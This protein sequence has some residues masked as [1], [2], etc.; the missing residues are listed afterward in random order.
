MLHPFK[1]WWISL[2]VLCSGQT[3]GQEILVP[4]WIKELK[5]SNHSIRSHAVTCDE[6]G[7]IYWAYDVDSMQRTMTTYAEKVNHQGELVWAKPSSLRESNRSQT[8]SSIAVHGPDV[9]V[10]GT[11][12]GGLGGAH[13]N[14]RLLKIDAATGNAIWQEHEDLGGN[15]FDEYSKIAFDDGKM[16]L[17]G[18][19][20]KI[21]HLISEDSYLQIRQLDT[22][23]KWENCYG[24]DTSNSK[25]DGGLVVDMEYVYAAGTTTNFNQSS[26]AFLGN[27]DKVTGALKDSV[28]FKIMVNDSLHH[29]R[30]RDMTTDGQYLYLC[31]HTDFIYQRGF[32]AKYTKSLEEVW[33]VVY[34][35]GL[36]S[37]NHAL[38]YDNQSLWI[39]GKASFTDNNRDGLL[40]QYSSDGDLLKELAWNTG[41]Y[42]TF[43]AIH[44]DHESIYLSGT[45]NYNAAVLLR[46]VKWSLNNNETAQSKFEIFPNP[47]QGQ[48]RIHGLKAGMEVQIFN[49][50]GQVVYRTST[51]SIDLSWLA[52][53]IYIASIHKNGKVLYT[54]KIVLG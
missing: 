14:P 37:H 10:T 7:Y 20:R 19:C 27:F 32:V 48:F 24:S 23:G 51:N 54:S 21:G 50:L 47:S 28:N 5:R 33:T 52:K 35:N 40:L 53:G 16:Y 41:E 25:L 46:L 38:H 31:G 6:D 3:I 30:I 12:Y 26:D 44:V 36:S 11:W 13:T 43:N 22:G 9:Y 39:A 4:E 15:G 45:K 49:L 29:A 42:E 34:N 17:A 2:L 18:T 8:S 1:I